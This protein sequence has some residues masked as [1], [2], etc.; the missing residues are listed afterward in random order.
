MED[1]TDSAE[2]YASR[3]SPILSG[4]IYALG[5]LFVVTVVW[6]NCFQID[7]VV[8]SNGTVKSNDISATITNVSSGYIEEYMMEDA[9][10][11][12]F[13]LNSAAETAKAFEL[14]EVQKMKNIL[15][16]IIYLG[17]R[18]EYDKT[19]NFNGG[20][21]ERYEEIDRLGSCHRHGPIPGCLW[22]L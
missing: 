18:F 13:L 1:M 15:D 10:V 12:L 14:L 8:R 5:A 11:A 22:L 4:V 17:L 3:P 2:V 7:V 9:E 16:N 6:M 20:K 19:F 21:N